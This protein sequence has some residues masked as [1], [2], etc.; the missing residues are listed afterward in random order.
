MPRSLRLFGE[1]LDHRIGVLLARTS[2]QNRYLRGVSSLDFAYPPETV[3]YSTTRK[4]CAARTRGCK[5]SGNGVGALSHIWAARPSTK[6]NGALVIYIIRHGQTEGN[7]AKQ[8]QGRSNRP[9]NDTGIQQAEDARTLLDAAGVRF[10]RVYASPL[11]RARQTADIV[12][13]GVPQLEDDRLIEMDYGPY[14]GMSLENPAPE[15]LAFF[16]DFAHNPAPEGMEQLDDVVARMGSFLEDVRAF[17]ARED[18]LVST[19]AI[20]L[21][22][23]LEYLTPDSNGSYWSTYIGNCA[24]YVCGTDADGNWT[25]ARKWEAPKEVS[26]ENNALKLMKLPYD[27]TV[28]KVNSIAD[29]DFSAEIL[30]VGKTDE[31]LSLVCPT[32]NVPAATVAREDGWKAFRIDGVLDF[33]LIGILSRVSGVLADNGIGIFAVSTF[34]TDYILVKTP[35]FEKAG[36]ALAAAGYDVDAG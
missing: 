11:I 4:S 17:A 7:A 12:A 19:H 21:K 27:L 15:V 26:M 3:F 1:R 6:Q 36:R 14:E 20:A 13:E 35:D 5:S 10:S 25:A 30:F 22:G 33:S 24:V 8:L 28:C 23:A 31:E 18:I 34:N 16:K 9:L 29:V 2:V 32:R